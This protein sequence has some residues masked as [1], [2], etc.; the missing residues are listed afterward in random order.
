MSS[1]EKETPS[2]KSLISGG[3]YNQ[4]YIIM[5]DESNTDKNKFSS[6]GHDVFFKCGN[7]CYKGNIQFGNL[8]LNTAD[9]PIIIPTLQK[10]QGSFRYYCN[11]NNVPKNSDY[12]DPL[13]F[14]NDAADFL[15]NE[16]ISEGVEKELRKM[17]S[18][19]PWIDDDEVNTYFELS[20]N[21]P[22]FMNKVALVATKTYVRG[23]II[24]SVYFDHT[25]YFVI[26]DGE[27][28]QPLL[29]VRFPD[30][31]RHGQGLHISS[32]NEHRLPWKKLTLWH[33]LFPDTSLVENLKHIPKLKTLS[34]SSKNYQQ[35]YCIMKSTWD[36]NSPTVSIHHDVLFR[37]GSWCY[38]GRVQLT[39]TLS[40]SDIPFVIPA[41]RVQQSRLDYTCDVSAVPTT[42][43]FASVLS[44]MQDI[45]PYIEQEIAASESTLDEL[46]D[47]LT[48]MNLGESVK[49]W[50]DGDPSNSFFEFKIAVDDDTSA[51]FKNMELVASKCYHASGI[52]TVTIIFQH[53][54]YVCVQ[55][56]STENPLLDSRFPDV[57]GKGRGYQI[58]AYSEGIEGWRNL[59]KVSIW[60]TTSALEQEFRDKAIEYAQSKQY[61][62]DMINNN[63]NSDV[64][65]SSMK[66]LYDDGD[67]NTN[68]STN[69]RSS[70]R[71]D[72]ADEPETEVP[73]VAE[74]KVLI[75]QSPITSKSLA[76]ATADSDN[77][78]H[79]SYSSPD[80]AV[81]SSMDDDNAIKVKTKS[82][83]IDPDSF[84]D[85]STSLASDLGRESDH[86]AIGSFTTIS[87]SNI[88][89]NNTSIKNN[90]DG[91]PGGASSAADGKLDTS[92]SQRRIVG[93][94]AHH[95]P[96]LDSLSKRMDEIRSSM[97]NGTTDNA[98]PWDS[99]GRPLGALSSSGKSEK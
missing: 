23:L 88:S 25:I 86:A 42:S 29:D 46:I 38:S 72:D 99:L 16:M 18:V 45:S 7:W 40:L 97:V 54:I 13:E 78:N 47:R 68:D 44:Y 81:A 51:I 50:L 31:S 5:H 43:P 9:L 84:K 74:R 24:I 2:A 73:K 63:S 95:L 65:S 3:G 37:F 76:V 34:V 93:P 83:S 30:I 64:M 96:K 11:S 1:D 94:R 92:V 85:V 62:D 60:Q 26:K 87:G 4:T 53:S 14:L 15:G 28:D 89:S 61:N 67:D 56:G 6:D 32:Y 39:P 71:H 55:D 19:F 8:K 41:L 69:L 48:K 98:A 33:I 91:N 52:V 35:T 12:Y 17:S 90:L 22:T 57:S 80:K 36:A 20:A 58:Q 10:Q 75:V 49:R 70:S 77:Y 59:R 27:G 66:E 79:T 21:V 82:K